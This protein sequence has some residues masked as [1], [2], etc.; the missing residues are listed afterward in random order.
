MTWMEEHD[1]MLLHPDFVVKLRDRITGYP[2]ARWAWYQCHA[3]D[4]VHNGN[5][6]YLIVGPTA[7]FQ[8]PPEY[9]PVP[10]TVH[11]MSPFQGFVDLEAGRKT[12]IDWKEHYG[13]EANR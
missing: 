13:M 1:P 6:F 5:A 8:V 10:S 2:G 9:F 4:S 11:S 12:S 7:T 3:L